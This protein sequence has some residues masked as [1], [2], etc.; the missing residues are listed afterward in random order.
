MGGGGGAIEKVVNMVP[1]I[2]NGCFVVLCLLF[3]C[4]YL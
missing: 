1:S 3:L 4:T 2:T